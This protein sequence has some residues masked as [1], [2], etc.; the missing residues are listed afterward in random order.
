MPEPTFDTRTFPGPGL[1]A[2]GRWAFLFCLLLASLR[3]A[4][5]PSIPRPEPA[6][7]EPGAEELAPTQQLLHEGIAVEFDLKT[8]DSTSEVREGDDVRFRWTVSDTATGEPL[9]GLYPAAWMDLMQPGEK[10]D[11]ELCIQRVEEF[12]G[13]SI[14]AKAELD[15]NVYYVLALNDDPTIS[16]VDPLFGFGGTKLLALIHLPSL[17]EDW[18]L[19]KDARHLFVSMPEAN[20]VAVVATNNWRL[21]TTLDVGPR[22][23][24]MS[25]QPDGAYL[26]VALDGAGDGH[27]SGVAAIDTAELEVTARIA[28]GAGPHEIA[29]SPDSR[30]AFVSNEGADTVSVIDVFRLEKVADIETGPRPVSIA[31]STLAKTAYAAHAG[32]GT[33]VAIDGRSLEVVARMSSR[34]GLGQIRFAPQGRLGFAVNPQT[35]TVAI[36]DAAKNRIVQTGLLKSGPDQVAFSEELAYIRHR[37]SETVLMIPLSEVGEEGRAVPVVDFPGG[38]TPFGLGRQPSVAPA[39]VQAPGAVAVLVA[40]PGDEMIYYYKEGMAAPMGGFRNYDRQPRAVMIVDRSVQERTQPGVYETT[41]KVRT[42]GRYRVAFFLD[43]PRIIHCFDAEVKPNPRL[44]EERLQALPVR[45][46]PLQKS[47][48]VGIGEEVRL[49]F[50]LIDPVT[51]GPARGL[52]DV[53]AMAQTPPNWQRRQ[54]AREVEEGLYEVSF[55]LPKPGTY[56]VLLQCPSERLRFYQ[57]PKVMLYAVAAKRE[58]KRTEAGRGQR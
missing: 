35:D 22:P 27:A 34:P 10:F 43:T 9:A 40:N 48:T 13:G 50:R 46:E 7:E 31:Y 21:L 44:E 51:N 39:I 41:A 25:I 3:S 38:Q 17:G 47:A 37:G 42:P 32:D 11:P 8:I 23:R 52:H 55:V 45:V 15:L 54:V 6:A 57:S 24:R 5:A 1:R 28:T 58:V 2:A 56:A 49:R 36:I 29:L 19:S 20:Q 33:I 14:L 26:W 30:R 18:A 4:A 53:V 12:V 16:V